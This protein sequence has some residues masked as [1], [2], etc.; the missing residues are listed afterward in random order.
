MYI[1]Q[2]RYCQFSSID[3]IVMR[4]GDYLILK[5]L[6]AQLINFYVIQ[7]IRLLTNPYL[8]S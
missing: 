4:D 5:F 7:L 2:L 6:F 3:S 1:I 8:L